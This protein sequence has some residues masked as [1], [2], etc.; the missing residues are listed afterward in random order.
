MNNISIFTTDTNLI[1]KSWGN[2][3]ETITGKTTK[4]VC[5]QNLLT[6]IPEI[7]TRGLLHYFQEV[8]TEGT[9]KILSPTFHHYLI[10]CPPITPSIYYDKMQQRVTI[11][12][13]W[14]NQII[15]GTIVTI[16]DITPRL[17]AEKNKQQQQK[18]INEKMSDNLGKL[19]EE[20]WRVRQENV[21]QIVR[22][23]QEENQLKTLINILKKEHFNPSV[24][25][26]ILQVLAMSQINAVEP[27]SELLKDGETDLRIYA[28]LALG[29]QHHPA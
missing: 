1:I 23:N 3:L 17:D 11:A 19:G 9:V 25:N 8:I 2:W 4:N 13:W 26:S 27:L 20:N 21:N 6:I 18:I 14:E 12:P 24:L 5:G 10:P 16:E 15:V 29:E 7:E 22:E 28:A